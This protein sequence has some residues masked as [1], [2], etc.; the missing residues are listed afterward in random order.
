MS[1]EVTL[2]LVLILLLLVGGAAL[3][4]STQRVDRAAMTGRLDLVAK[5]IPRLGA[6]GPSTPNHAV[7]V[8]QP[9][10]GVKAPELN[11]R[12]RITRRLHLPDAQSSSAYLAARLGLAAVLA[13]AAFALSA[14]HLS[15]KLAAI[16]YLAA[17]SCGYLGW[18]IPGML[19]D[20]AIKMHVRDVE[21]ALPEGLELL[22]ICAEAGLSLEDG[23][24]RVITELRWSQPAL[25]EEL[26]LTSA[27]LKILPDRE[28]ALGGLATRVDVQSVRSVVTA[29]SQTLRYGTPLAQ[30]LR[31]TASELRNDAL[32]RMENRANQLPPLLTLP[33][34][35]FIMPTIFLII[36]GP[37]VLKV[38]DIFAHR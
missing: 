26:A 29:L 7:L 11:T 16:P 28:K 20:H 36:G 18:M 21:S 2:M 30:A 23:L 15:G 3:I 31:N 5:E 34:M 37:A 19:L 10:K 9:G 13:G 35:L 4:A 27:D 38:M 25:A 24:D 14:P 32:L 33:M 17:L 1:I 12:L 8:R 6:A 22:V